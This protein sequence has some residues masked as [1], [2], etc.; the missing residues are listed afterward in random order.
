L[1]GALEELD[2]EPPNALIP[3]NVR[4]RLSRIPC[5]HVARWRMWL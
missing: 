4:R 2:R 1:N 5:T 3:Q